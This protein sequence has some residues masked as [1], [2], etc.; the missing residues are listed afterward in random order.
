LTVDEY[1][2]G[3]P[4]AV[5][6][7]LR[8]VRAVVRAAAPG[9]EEIISYRMPALRQH[10]VLVYYAAFKGHIGFYPPIRG[11]AQLERAAAPFAGEKGNLRFPFTEP[12]PYELIGQLTAFRAA[13]DRA[14][15]MSMAAVKR[16][17]PPMQTG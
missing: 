14:K 8:Q 4:E 12:I 17:T 2:A 5:Q 3:F 11:C 6:V 9:A 16:K 13:Q 10:G 1:I 7:M 15:A